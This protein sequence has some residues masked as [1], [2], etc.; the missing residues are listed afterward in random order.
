[1]EMAS[2]WLKRTPKLASWNWANDLLVVNVAGAEYVHPAKYIGRSM[3]AVDLGISPL[4]SALTGLP[5][6]YH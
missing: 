4:T 6:A 3:R 5:T 2:E 1:M